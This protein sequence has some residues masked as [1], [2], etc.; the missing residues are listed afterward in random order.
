MCF[1]EESG[2]WGGGMNIVLTK[3]DSETDRGDKIMPWVK[4]SL[5]ENPLSVGKRGLVRRHTLENRLENDEWE[6]HALGRE[7]LI[8]E[9][10]N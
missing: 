5:G 10:K 3:W 6:E 8:R 9:I 2:E 7:R 1:D 4:R